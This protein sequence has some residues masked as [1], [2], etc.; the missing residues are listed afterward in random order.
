MDE[1]EEAEQYS[2]RTVGIDVVGVSLVPI[3]SRVWFDGY[4]GMGYLCDPSAVIWS[5]N[6]LAVCLLDDP[7]HRERMVRAAI[8]QQAGAS[9]RRLGTGRVSS[10]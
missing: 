1:D 6:G 4:C 10:L 9:P 8:R 7:M 3:L 2:V 5:A